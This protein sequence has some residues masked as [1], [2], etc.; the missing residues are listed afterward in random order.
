MS[1]FLCISRVLSRKCSSQLYRRLHQTSVPVPL[2]DDQDHHIRQHYITRSINSPRIRHVH[3][4]FKPVKHSEE[5]DG[6]ENHQSQSWRLSRVG[7]LLGTA[8]ILCGADQ[9]SKDRQL[10]LAVKQDNVSQVTQLLNSGADVNSRHPL[11]WTP[12][13]TA[14]VN[15][16]LQEIQLLL[17]RGA[18]VNMRDDFST[19]RR[20]AQQLGMGSDRVALIRDREFCSLINHHVS[21]SGFTALH[22]AIVIDNREVV[23]CLLESGADPTIENHRGLAPSDYCTNQEILTLLQQHTVMI[24]E[25]EAR[26]RLEERRQFPLEDRLREAMVGQEGPITAAAAAIRR[27]ENG[28]GDDE[29]P[30]VFLFLG[31]SGIGKTELAKQIAKYIHKDKKKVAK[32]IGAPPG[33]V[34]YDQGGQ[35]T[36]QL[37]DCPDAVVLFDEVDKAHPDV[38]T[39]LLQLFDEGRL[40]DG[41][42]KTIS[43]KDA[44]FVMTSNLA[45]DEIASHALQ[46]RKEASK[47]AKKYRHSEDEPEGHIEISREFKEQVVEPILK[48]HFKRDEFLG[49]ITEMLYFLPFSRSELNQLV[50]RELCTWQERALQ[51]HDIQLSWDKEVLDVLADGYNV[52]YGARSIQH[53][54]ERSVVNKLAAAYE[55]GVIGRSSHVTLVI[56]GEEGGPASIKLQVYSLTN[57]K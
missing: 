1:R 39:V 21:C 32:L 7:A 3:P 25:M 30:L 37:S 9:H 20:V 57:K 41:Q 51:R 40:T 13:H 43:C 6:H 49:R 35:L 27:R 29:H 42:G 52:K 8:L 22:Y 28:W 2:L 10:M 26:R 11:G 12:L 50:E 19:A 44:I 14:V 17:E 34:G 54:V 38:L 46:L 31:S 48:F 33:Y 4:P 47:A 56:N 16:N 36:S 53:E 24:E 5:K 45:S 55:E 18:D 23:E 15:G